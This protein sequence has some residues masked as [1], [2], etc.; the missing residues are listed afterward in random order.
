MNFL[1]RRLKDSKDG[2]LTPVKTLLPTR[3]EDFFCFAT[4][5]GV[6]VAVSI[7]DI[8]SV[9]WLSKKPSDQKTYKDDLDMLSNARFY[10]RNR[11][12]VY[13]VFF[14]EFGDA[15]T[16]YLQLD[17]V[18]FTEGE[19]F[20]GESLYGKQVSFPLNDMVLVELDSSILDEGFQG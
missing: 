3:V 17:S 1:W 8:E 15:A 5:N 19:S 9:K 18:E 6:S 13:L 14:H 4:N 20:L 11:P 10:L 2:C 7:N 12:E 16:F